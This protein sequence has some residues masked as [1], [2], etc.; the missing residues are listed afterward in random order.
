MID[1]VA[2]EP[3]VGAFEQGVIFQ[4]LGDGQ[5]A[6]L[7]GL[8]DGLLGYHGGHKGAG[9]LCRRPVNHRFPHPNHMGDAA[10]H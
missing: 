5:T 9:K 6:H 8:R 10:L 1:T 2:R 4:R 3:P 7:Y